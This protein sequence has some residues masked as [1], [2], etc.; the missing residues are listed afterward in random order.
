MR[1]RKT[2]SFSSEA[3]SSQELLL[4]SRLMKENE[5]YERPIF[6]QDLVY[7]L[8]LEMKIY[9]YKAGFAIGELAEQH[10]P[11]A[12]TLEKLLLG[13]GMGKVVYY[14][15]EFH[16]VITSSKRKG[17]NAGTNMHV[18]E[19]G[20]ISGFLSAESGTTINVAETHCANY[21]DDFCQFLA[22][23]DINPY[24]DL[25]A[26]E[27]IDKAT[28][29]LSEAIKAE[30]KY[31]KDYYLLSFLPLME[32]PLLNS[33]AKLFYVLGQNLA[34]INPG[35]GE[36]LPLLLNYLHIGGKIGKNGIIEMEYSHEMSS[37]GFVLL[38]E[39]LVRGY[40]E[41]AL[42]CKVNVKQHINKGA[43]RV[44]VTTE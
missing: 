11:G 4:I 40:L 22:T 21:K 10:Y 16:A 39:M 6:I 2:L 12:S 36:T 43:Y 27:S 17:G 41:N 30:N 37:T 13:A 15:F 25:F 35:E 1:S 23:R 9:A 34:K 7:N 33:A 14:P 28:E 18:F 5:S 3:S 8:A 44:E 26:I 38:N 42:H 24:K 32:K 31:N 29:I 19:S 20:L